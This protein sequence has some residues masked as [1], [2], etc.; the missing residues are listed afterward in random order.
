MR[1]LFDPTLGKLFTWLR[2]MGYDAHYQ[3]YYRAGRINQLVKD[4]RCF[5]SRHKEAVAEYQNCIWL[6]ANHAEEQLS[7]LK[8]KISLKIDRSKWFTRRLKCN[9]LLKKPPKE[10]VRENVPDYIYHQHSAQILFCPCCKRCFWPGTHKANMIR[11][12]TKWS[13]WP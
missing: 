9:V 3:S 11:Q 10:A 5:L 12:L 6:N 4:E 7:K 8:E 1:F 13:I 2:I